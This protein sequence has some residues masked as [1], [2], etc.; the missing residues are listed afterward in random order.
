M[1]GH[2]CSWS[3]GQDVRFEQGN[4]VGVAS[5]A[6]VFNAGLAVGFERRAGSAL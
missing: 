1:H 5:I 6:C 4:D 2:R 3:S